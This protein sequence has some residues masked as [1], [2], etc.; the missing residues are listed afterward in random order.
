MRVHSLIEYRVTQRLLSVI[1]TKKH[2]FLT[3]NSRVLGSSVQAHL[4]AEKIKNSR[5]PNG[6][7]S[8]LPKRKTRVFDN[9][10]QAR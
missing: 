9:D 5:F 2:P 8:K 10:A 3:M 4:H 1:E 7:Q 6:S